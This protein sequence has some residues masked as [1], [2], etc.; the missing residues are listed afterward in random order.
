MDMLD[1]AALAAMPVANDPFPHVVVP[2]FVPP[3]ALREWPKIP[4]VIGSLLHGAEIA[5]SISARGFVNPV[6]R[7]DPG[8]Q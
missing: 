7:L 4:I 6:I 3:D 2:N 8:A 1:Y 5:E